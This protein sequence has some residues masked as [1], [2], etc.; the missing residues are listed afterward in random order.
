[1]NEIEPPTTKTSSEDSIG[2]EL[3][4]QQSLVPYL[5]SGN[6]WYDPVWRVL[7]RTIFHAGRRRWMPTGIRR[8]IFAVESFFLALN[9][10]ERE[11]VSWLNDPLHRVIVPENEN[12]TIPGFW[13]TEFYTAS[14]IDALKRRLR[15]RDWK[16]ANWTWDR[17]HPARSI[18]RYRGRPGA[19]GWER[20]VSLHADGGGSWNPDSLNA[21]LPKGVRSVQ[22]FAVPT[23]SSLTAVVAAFSLTTD[24]ATSLQRTLVADHAPRLR[25]M[26]PTVQVSEPLFVGIRSVIEE[27]DQLHRLGRRWLSRE[28]PGVFAREAGANHPVLDLL[29]SDVYD[30]FSARRDAGRANYLRALGLGE[31]EWDIDYL[32]SLP[33]FRL[34]GQ[35]RGEPFMSGRDEFRRKHA[36]TTRLADAFGE[37]WHGAYGEKTAESIFWRLSEDVLGLVVRLS[38]TPLLELKYERLSQLRD[39][40]HSTQR[41]GPVRSARILRQS[42]LDN[43]LDVTTVAS[44]ISKLTGSPH[45]YEWHV[46]QVHRRAGAWQTDPE[47]KRRPRRV[48][49]DW[50]AK[51]AEQQSELAREL[52]QGD[53]AL[54]SILGVVSSLD[55]SI[56]GIRGQRAALTLSVLS[57]VAAIAAIY[58]AL[59]SAPEMFVAVERLF[60][61]WR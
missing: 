51:L 34:N 3:E 1:M 14:H 32:P 28:M 25:L 16:Y 19:L 49:K 44:D 40:A 55:A 43:S 60:D 12:V 41:R 26:G 10:R 17:L 61:E 56:E 59:V 4:R 8:G 24:A 11:K 54:L 46:P 57:F 22:L 15:G 52:Q 37:T 45:L 36:L 33:G 58:V 53:T 7:R 20:I 31:N 29:V 50:L 13:V 42:V 23:G 9:S 30:P 27:R 47:T 21:R 5:G 48:Q 2:I 6:R 18:E 38:L 35:S 39:V